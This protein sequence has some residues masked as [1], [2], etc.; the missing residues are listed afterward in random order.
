MQP[1]RQRASKSNKA[2]FR[3]AFGAGHPGE[4]LQAVIAARKCAAFGYCN[5]AADPQIRWRAL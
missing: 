4:I 1:R 2:E 5:P 3:I